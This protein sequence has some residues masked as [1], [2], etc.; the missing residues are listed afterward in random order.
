MKYFIIHSYDGI[1]PDIVGTFLSEDR[2]D[3]EAKEIHR[4]MS[5][6]DV[7]FWLNID[8]WG[9]PT[10]GAYSAGFFEE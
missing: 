4:V 9:Q 7:I 6:D 10:V 2:R 3:N 8:E 5:E 1:D